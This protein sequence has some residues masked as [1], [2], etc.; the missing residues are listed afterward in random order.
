MNEDEVVAEV[1]TE[2]VVVG[3]VEVV[4]QVVA[5]SSVVKRVT[6]NENVQKIA[7]VGVAPIIVLLRN[8]IHQS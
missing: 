8:E 5:V 2:V 6:C 4:V 1:M 7:A 3:E